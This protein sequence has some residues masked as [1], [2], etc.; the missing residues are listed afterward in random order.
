MTRTQ[1][2][3]LL[4]VVWLTTIGAALLGGAYAHKYRAIIR[5][6]L[7]SLQSSPVVQTNLYNLKIEKLALPEGDGRDGAV[8]VLGDGL[9]LVNRRGRF[10]YVT[11]ERKLQPL[12][13]QVPIDVAEFE[14]DPYNRTTTDK[15]RFSVKDILV[16][17][18]PSG[19]RVVASYLYWHR[20]RSCN[21][22][23]VSAVETTRDALLSGSLGAGTWRTLLDSRCYELVRG[24]DSTSHVVTLGAGGRLI[25]M[26]DKQ[27]LV[28]TGEFAAQ[29]VGET[30][31]QRKD[32][33]GRTMLI[34]IPTATTTEYT[35]GHRNP[36]GLAI[37]PDG[38]I[39]LTE[40][41]A[42]GGD[43]LNL[44]VKG[45][46]YGSPWVSY[47]TQY[48]MMVWPNSKTQ[49]KHEGYTKPMYSW[50]PSI[51]PSQLIVVQGHSF[52]WWTDDLLVGALASQTMFRVRVEDDR[53]IFVEPIVIGHR[54][55]DMVE[56]PSGTIVAKTDDNFLIFIDNLES[57]PASS[58]DPVT[59][60]SIVAGQC[61]S[62]HNFEQGGPSGLGP[63]LWAVVGRG[64]ARGSGYAYSDALKKVGGDWTPDR[65]RA[66][67][68]DPAQFAPGT[69]MAIATKYSDQ[70]LND[71]IAYLQT[72]R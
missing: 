51:A 72:L 47:G 63:N 2:W 32:S 29:F 25:S 3:L 40:H 20:D 5:A 9:L 17:T 12:S 7:K 14:A 18:I 70:Q 48:E 6:R 26:S 68:A 57:A 41:G 19:I 61:K 11:N 36:Q 10:W 62:C 13:L 65:L 46:N 39:W 35:T 64:V 16:Q 69:R 15:D 67:V 24:P 56:T 1:R 66:F 55:R 21:S 37:G 22:L 54:L 59:R 28:T 30:A 8:D 45:R 23:R 71:L 27:L 60:G 42:R 43:E 33:S 34:D 53:V 31:A 4:M 38:R 49:G 50:V 44:V 52:P 58:L